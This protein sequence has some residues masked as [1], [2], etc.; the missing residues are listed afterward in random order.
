[1]LVWVIGISLWAKCVREG[2]GSSAGA[3]GDGLGLQ[4]LVEA[5]GAPFAAE[6][7]LLVTAERHMRGHAAPASIDGHDAGPDAFRD[8]QRPCRIGGK[9]VAAEAEFAV[10]GQSAGMLVIVE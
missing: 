4:V 5:G 10:V 1:M 9:D 7:A 8:A 3:P 6:A 2:C